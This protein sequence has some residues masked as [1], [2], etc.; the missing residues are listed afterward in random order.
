M[1]PAG[2]VYGLGELEQPIAVGERVA[3]ATAS[4][5]EE[6]DAGVCEDVEG[7]R[8]QGGL[9]AHRVAMIEAAEE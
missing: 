9:L 2:E 3:R 8:I 4:M 6:A 5:A 1:R 7:N